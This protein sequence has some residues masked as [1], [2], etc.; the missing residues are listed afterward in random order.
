MYDSC[1]FKISKSFT[2]CS[3]IKLPK[4]ILKQKENKKSYNICKQ[5]T[6]ET[7]SL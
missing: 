6:C 4:Y 1:V 3:D 5:H 2:S 7:V